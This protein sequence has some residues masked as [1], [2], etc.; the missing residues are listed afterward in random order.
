MRCSASRTLP[1]VTLGW[2]TSSTLACVLD[3]EV[4]GGND[5]PA[6]SSG[7]DSSDPTSPSPTA[8][9]TGGDPHPEELAVTWDSLVPYAATRGPDGDVLALLT[10]AGVSPEGPWTISRLDESGEQW[11]VGLA[12]GYPEVLTTTGAGLI[13]VGGALFQSADPLA[14]EA[15]LWLLDGDGTLQAE[16]ALG[17]DFSTVIGI[18]EGG[19]ML[20]TTTEYRGAGGGFPIHAELRRHA[21][22]GEVV[23]TLT[24]DDGSGELAGAS[25]VAVGPDGHAYVA[26][27]RVDVLGQLHR[28]APDGTL[29]WSTPLEL[30]SAWA[31][32]SFNTRLFD[33]AGQEVLLVD[34][35][36]D[37]LVAH[38]FTT[39]GA[40]AASFSIA[41]PTRYRNARFT[42]TSDGI[43]CAYGIEP[44]TLVIEAWHHDGT[45]AW[46]TSRELPGTTVADVTGVVALPDAVAVVGA[47]N[48]ETPPTVEGIEG[49]VRFVPIP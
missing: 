33:W 22:D 16:Q 38:G 41:D 46:T 12:G 7:A 49:F 11:M 5:P 45:A 20:W 47:L 13:A 30:G 29:M 14:L 27:S 8:D 23:E 18:G 25:Q 36:S 3:P 35:G 40:S 9:S 1:L 15:H 17:S 26:S 48:T 24:F 10:P 19:G 28:V 34:N 44:S 2:L 43:A 21:P 4:V 37:D 31:G 32:P 42:S 39:D 6:G